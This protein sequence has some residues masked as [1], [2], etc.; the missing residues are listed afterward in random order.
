[1]IPVITQYQLESDAK[2]QNSSSFSKAVFERLLLQLVEAGDVVCLAFPI[3]ML[4]FSNFL[5]DN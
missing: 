4:I 5:I 2:D 3:K 1:M